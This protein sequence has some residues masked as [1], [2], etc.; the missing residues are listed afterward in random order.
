M[1]TWYW[2][3]Y[4]NKNSISDS[5]QTTRM[6]ISKGNAYHPDILHPFFSTPFS[7]CQRTTTRGSDWLDVLCCFLGLLCTHI[8]PTAA[9]QKRR[10]SA[11]LMRGSNDSGE[12]TWNRVAK[13]T[14]ADAGK[15]VRAQFSKLVSAWFEIERRRDAEVIF[16]SLDTCR[17]ILP[18]QPGD[19]WVASLALFFSAKVIFYHQNGVWGSL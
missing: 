9:K 15:P 5:M 13:L 7:D 2:L 1:S 3:F 18:A 10:H 6:N 17:G 11:S 19:I 14:D 12:V 4:I 8:G 16:M